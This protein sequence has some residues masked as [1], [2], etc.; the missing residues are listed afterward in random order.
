M[1][2]IPALCSQCLA[3]S[4][5]LFSV[6]FVTAFGPSK[7]ELSKHVAGAKAAL[8]I[9]VV[10]LGAAGTVTQLLRA[11]ALGICSTFSWETEPGMW[12][13]TGRGG[14]SPTVSLESRAQLSPCIGQS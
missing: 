3:R 6:S 10:S 13:Q 5:S 4:C 2:F 11:L 9:L 8:G 14:Q 1:L 12:L 7:Q